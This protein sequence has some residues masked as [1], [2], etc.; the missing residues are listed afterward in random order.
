[1]KKIHNII[2]I[3]VLYAHRNPRDYT[4]LYVHAAFTV[5]SSVYL[6]RSMT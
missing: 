5:I 3:H 6:F 4:V 2:Q 1:M